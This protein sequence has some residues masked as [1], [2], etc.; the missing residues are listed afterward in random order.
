[1]GSEER[2]PDSAHLQVRDGTGCS[3]CR[4]DSRCAGLHGAGLEEPLMGCRRPYVLLTGNGRG[5][6]FRLVAALLKPVRLAVLAGALKKSGTVNKQVPDGGNEMNRR[7][8]KHEAFLTLP[9]PG[10]GGDGQY[11][12]LLIRWER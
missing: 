6:C 7:N 11:L 1:M 3:I 2:V 12:W 8:W 4:H 9:G 10:C 5:G